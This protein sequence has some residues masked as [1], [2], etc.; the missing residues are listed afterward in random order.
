MIFPLLHAVQV[1]IQVIGVDDLPCEPEVIFESS[2]FC[3][4]MISIENEP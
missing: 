3:E 4:G 1:V 2:E